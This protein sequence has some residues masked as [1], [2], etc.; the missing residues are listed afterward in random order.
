MRCTV[1]TAACAT[2][3]SPR[4]TCRSATFPPQESIGPFPNAKGNYLTGISSAAVSRRCWPDRR[5]PGAGGSLQA[6][7]DR[8]RPRILL[9]AV[10]RRPTDRPGER[11]RGQPTRHANGD[12]PTTTPRRDNRLLQGR[13]AR[14]RRPRG[15]AL[16]RP[17]APSIATQ[18]ASRMGRRDHHVMRARA[19]IKE[20]HQCP[21]LRTVSLAGERR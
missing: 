15:R 10:P 17:V 1:C 14:R 7:P 20:P 3:S 12:R 16:L 19:D 2:I 8:A 21:Y 4:S 13:K 18:T 9:S 11:T 5:R 6:R